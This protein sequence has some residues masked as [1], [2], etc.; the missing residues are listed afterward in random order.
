MSRR[1]YKEYDNY[2]RHQG[3]DNRDRDSRSNHYSNHSNYSNHSKYSNHSNYS[4]NSHHEDS[5]PSE[6]YDRS[7]YSRSVERFPVQR[8]KG[9]ATRKNNCSTNKHDKKEFS[10]SISDEESDE[11]SLRAK[12]EDRKC[13]DRKCEDRKSEDRKCE[14]RKCERRRH[15]HKIK[16]GPT[17]PQGSQGSQGI[18][19]GCSGSTGSQGP[20]GPQGDP[21]ANGNTGSQGLQGANGNAGS[22]G[23]QGNPGTPGLQGAPGAIGPQGLSGVPGSQ[24]FIGP[25]GTTGPQGTIAGVTGSTVNNAILIT[26]ATGTTGGFGILNTYSFTTMTIGNVQYNSLILSGIT[27]SPTFQ[28]NI[29]IQY[30]LNNIVPVSNAYNNTQYANVQFPVSIAP[31]PGGSPAGY[32][33]TGGIALWISPTDL[34]IFIGS[35]IGTNTEG[36]E[37]GPIVFTWINIV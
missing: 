26:G 27:P 2:D 5:D 19:T 20:Q 3:R 8:G 6:E 24:G 9:C 21:G 7:Q 30:V 25:Q 14:D 4:R 1:N 37:F 36:L 34:E 15:L 22:Q 33:T 10:F 23:P 32:S 13:E 17:G 12:R 16:I 31:K 28:Q 18:C 29:P 35:V 11:T